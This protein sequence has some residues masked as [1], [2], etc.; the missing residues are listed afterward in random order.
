M[1]LINEIIK[2]SVK[3]K[4]ILQPNHHDPNLQNPFR[5]FANYTQKRFPEYLLDTK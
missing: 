5:Q 1:S 3:E 2:H 4:L